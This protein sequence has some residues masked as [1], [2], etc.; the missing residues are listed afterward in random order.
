MGAA[1]SRIFQQ[2]IIRKVLEKLLF[3]LAVTGF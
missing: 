2:K 3:V 1:L